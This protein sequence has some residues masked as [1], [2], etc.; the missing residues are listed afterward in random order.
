[1]V[2]VPLK[3]ELPHFIVCGL[4]K[5]SLDQKSGALALEGSAYSTFLLLELELPHFV[6]RQT[7]K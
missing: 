6:F 7:G 5:G 1:M 2:L 3:L 4:R